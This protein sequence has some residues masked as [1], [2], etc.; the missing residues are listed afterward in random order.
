[1]HPIDL[2]HCMEVSAV[3]VGL[4]SNPYATSATVS[5]ALKI[6]LANTIINS[7]EAFNG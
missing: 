2:Q 7:L 3:A 1:M 4:Q 5:T 6:V